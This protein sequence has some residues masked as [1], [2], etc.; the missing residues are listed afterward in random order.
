MS[1]MGNGI[2]PTEVAKRVGVSKWHATH[3]DAT[4]T[5]NESRE[6]GAM[7]L[8]ERACK[9]GR[10]IADSLKTLVVEFWR[11]E[12]KELPDAR[13]NKNMIKVVNPVTS[14]FPSLPFRSKFALLE[15]RLCFISHMIW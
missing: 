8:M 1:T 7:K 5:T 2:N 4:R 13:D 3:A 6:W 10:T 14:A 11:R 12:T 15:T 9:G